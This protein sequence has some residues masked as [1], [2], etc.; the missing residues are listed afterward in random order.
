ML[1]SLRRASR[2]AGRTFGSSVANQAAY[3]NLGSQVRRD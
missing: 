1:I 3:L 2:N